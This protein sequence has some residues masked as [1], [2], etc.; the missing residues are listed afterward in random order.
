M[1][2]R[3]GS[4]LWRRRAQEPNRGRRDLRRAALATALAL[5]ALAVS[6]SASAA[7][8]SVAVGGVPSLSEQATAVGGL[9]P[10]TALGL[11]VVLAPRDEAALAALA[12][13][14]STP[15]SPSYHHY[16]SVGQFAARFGASAANVAAVRAT[17]RG[18]G[19]DPGALAPD[20]LSIAVTGSAAD[21]S[22]AFDVSLHR[23][24]EH[25]GRQVY[26]N[27]SSPRVPASL[28]G[29]VTDVLGLDNLPAAVPEGLIAGRRSGPIAHAASEPSFPGGGGPVPCG[30]ASTFAASLPEREYTIN[31]IAD[32]YRMDGLYAQGDFGAGVTVALNELEPY[33]S[34]AGDISAYEACFGITSPPSVT[35][36]EVAGGPAG[37]AT[38]EETAVDLENLLGLAPASNIDVYQGPNNSDG[39]YATLA[40]IVDSDSAQVISDSWG[41]CEQ[42]LTPAQIS[43]EQVLLYQAATQGQSFLVS[44]GDR[45]AEGCFPT[46]DPNFTWG[47]NYGSPLAVDDPASQPFATGVGGTTLDAAGPPPSETAWNDIDYGASGGG[48][49]TVWGMPNYQLYSGAAGIFDSYSSGTPCGD[50]SG[51]CREVP[52]VSADGSP[53]SGFV[54]TYQGAWQAVGGTSTAAPVWAG[55]IALADASDSAGCAGTPLGFLNPALYEVA[56]GAAHADAFNDVSVGDNSGT[57]IDGVPSGPYP[58][59]AGYDMTTGLGSP[60]ATDGSSPGLVAQLCA[61]SQVP[62]GAPASV[63]GLSI[64]DASP[65]T[66]VTIDGSGFTPY[67]Q[68]WFGSNEATAVTEIDPQH[69]S[70]IVPPGS[71]QVD[72]TV[73][74]ISGRS[75]T[76]SPDLFIYAPTETIN[77]PANGAV[78]TQGQ[79]LNAA[80]SCVAHAPASCSAPVADGAAIDTSA[81]GSH[82]FSVTATD[83][84]QVS[85]T[86]T[87][88]YSVVAKPAITISGPAPGGIYAQ[89][90]VLTAH[91]SCAASPPATI[92]SCTAPVA[93]GSAVDTATTGAHSFT[94]A[95]T[96]NFGITTTQTVTYTVVVAP[97]ATIASPANGAVYLRRA[98][99]EA[100]FA[101]RAAAPARIMS[102]SATA[103]KGARINTATLGRH[104]F[105][106]TAT[107]SFGVSSAVTVSYTV[108]AVRPT[109]GG[110]RETAS[111]WVER[112]GSGGRLPV[113]T[114]FTFSL[115]QAAS[116]TLSFARSAGGRMAGGRCVAPPLATSSAPACT[117]R[118]GAGTLT[119]K[120][121]RGANGLRFSGRTSSG[122]LPAGSYTVVVRAT[123]RSGQASVAL[124]LQ[125]TIAA[126][127]P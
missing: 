48:I 15:G 77:A 5:L 79:S 112:H 13:A 35:N 52:D 100:K 125:F 55:L 90:Q 122:Q 26:A 87:A 109:I 67:S 51:Y 75:T 2:S 116:V 46:N 96:D 17:L 45:G 74:K 4:P 47:N 69:I 105:T 56:A 115:D 86:S 98:A 99:V 82:Q 60:L 108:V 104:R 3:T 12:S 78:Y 59:T 8:A 28:R 29:V 114:T 92:A 21:A 126:P 38:S 19:L 58:A 106:L 73:T 10:T 57:F 36:I 33:A 127:K 31:E 63:S 64:T 16:L 22:R 65:G 97:S 84:N 27:T 117:R 41:Q 118:I 44:S 103:Q 20:G 91:F 120:A 93:N 9:A 61:A 80:Y 111:T 76:G 81:L 39:I 89:G 7:P 14:V 62:I 119:I 40:A 30:A 37:G 95:A 102:C 49:S 18:E 71:G 123:G 124:S 6:A 23:Y 32:A 83:A 72:V 1:W 70:A 101:C 25:S 110:L 34:E 94:V 66:S 113:G 43:Q 24:R 54:I 11:T 50:P 42:K 121:A 88:S 107:D 68:V 85:T 53:D